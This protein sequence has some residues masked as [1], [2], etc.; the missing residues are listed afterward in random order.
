MGCQ[1]SFG[2]ISTNLTWLRRTFSDLY[3]GDASR[4]SKL[5]DSLLNSPSSETMEYFLAEH[6][7]G[8]LFREAY[9]GNNL[10]MFSQSSAICDLNVSLVSLAEMFLPGET[11]SHGN[12]SVIFAFCI[13]RNELFYHSYHLAL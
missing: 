10:L 11:D 6:S 2:K 5:N 12:F 3:S 4:I 7:G 13:F 1:I 8:F 9:L